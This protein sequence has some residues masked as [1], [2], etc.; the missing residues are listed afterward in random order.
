MKYKIKND[1][2]VHN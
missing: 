1:D 2:H